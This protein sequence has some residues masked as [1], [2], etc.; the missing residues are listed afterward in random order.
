[1]RRHLSRLV[2]H[3][4]YTT[5]EQDG[6]RYWHTWRQWGNHCWGQTRFPVGRAITE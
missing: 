6:L 1:M 4:H 2:P 5:Y 3:R